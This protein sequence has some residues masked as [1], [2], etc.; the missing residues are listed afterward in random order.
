M[1]TGSSHTSEFDPIWR[2][3]LRLA[4]VTAKGEQLGHQVESV[5]SRVR[6][7]S[8]V[9]LA[10]VFLACTS[11]P[12]S[13]RPLWFDEILTRYIAALPNYEA[14]YKA[15]VNHTESSPPLFHV[16]SRLSGAALG[17]SSLGLRLPAMAGYL[18]MLVCVCFIVNRHA[19]P[20]Y[21]AIGALCSYLTYAPH[22]SIEAR[23]YGLLLGVS[24]IA[25]V[26]WQLA[27]RARFRAL[28]IGGLWLSLATALGIQFYAV[29]SFVAI[30]LGELVRTW[31]ARRIDLP[32]WAALGF[33]TVPLPFLLPLIRSNL[34]LK[35]GYFAPATMS[36]FV[37]GFAQTFLHMGGLLFA[38]FAVLV[39]TCTVVFS[40]RQAP[41]AAARDIPAVHEAV[42]WVGLLLSPIEA[43]LMG[44][45]LTG[46]YLPRYA[47]ITVIGF[48]LLLPLSLHRLFRSSK[49]AALVVLL[50]LGLCFGEWCARSSKTDDLNTSLSSWLRALDP[51]RLPIVVSDP[52]T[53]LP[54]AYSTNMDLSEVLVYIPD[55][56]EALRYRGVNTAEYN[57][58]GLR[59]IAPLHLPTYSSF[60]SS[61]QRFLVLWK[62]SPYDWIVPK[63]LDTGAEL[64][65]CA[66][67]GPHVLLLVDLPA[68]DA[69]TRDRKP[70]LDPHLVCNEKN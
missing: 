60:S 62:P 57:L 70:N 3:Y 39:V 26:C 53:Y 9:G 28:A 14:I 5:L 68:S 56:Q 4:V 2:T 36:R 16:I 61:H 1:A 59:A 18:A 17:W 22:Y 69:L 25:L 41:A 30:A 47:I 12:A 33:A 45:F 27:A 50:F 23:P 48:S 6:W 52:L 65:F 32:V 38:A 7:W 10:V 58:I 54:L 29:L 20:L 67:S 44:R 21:A 19:G 24:S 42:A 46:I 13:R 49:G 43:F 37:D 66:A 64:R 34:V 15:L 51:S 31:R 63:L 11:V 8:I 55:P 35:K 40:D